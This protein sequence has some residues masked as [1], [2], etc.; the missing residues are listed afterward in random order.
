ML[1][2]LVF[3][4]FFGSVFKIICA[5]HIKFKNIN[6]NEGLQSSSVY[7]SIEDEMGFLWFLTEKGVSQYDGS[8][9][10]YFEED[11]LLVGRGFY[12]VKKDIK[13]N[14]W[15]IS[16]DFRLFKK[17]N[18]NIVQVKT[19]DLI[20]W[21]DFDTNG[22]GYLLSRKGDI[23]KLDSN[24]NAKRIFESDEKEIFFNLIAIGNEQ[25][26]VT[27]EYGVYQIDKKGEKRRL[28][29]PIAVK[30]KVVVPR[31]FKLNEN[32]ILVSTFSGIFEVDINVNN[33]PEK[34]EGFDGIEFFCLYKN[35]NDSDIWLGSSKGIYRF[36]KGIIKKENA[37]VYL[38]G[39]IVFDIKEHSDNLLWIC[40]A[41]NGV[42]YCYLN[43]LNIDQKD[44]LKKSAIKFVKTD[45]KYVYCIDMDGDISVLSDDNK[46][47]NLFADKDIRGVKKCFE[48]KHDGFFLLSSNG[49]YQIK[50]KKIREYKIKELKKEPLYPI[51][52]DGL[53]TIY[54]ISKLGLIAGV[55]NK[56]KIVLNAT[57]IWEHISKYNPRL[58]AEFLE[59]SNPKTVFY[60]S[61]NNGIMKV[62][63]INNKNT[64]EKISF[65]YKISNIVST[66]LNTLFIGTYNKG[67]C[68]YNTS[69]LKFY[70]IS[71]GL[72]SNLCNKV[73][74][75]KNAIW[76]CTNKGISR[77][78]LNNRDEVV[79][80]TNFTA[81]DVLV[82]NEVNDLTIL[83]G[84]VYAA[85]NLGVSVFSESIVMN[86]NNPHFF[87]DQVLINNKPVSINA[88]Y[89]LSYYENN[90]TIVYKAVSFR[91][92][93]NI[94]YKYLFINGKD[95]VYTFTK[96][97]RIQY[98]SL[99]PGNYSLYI[100]VRDIDGNWCLNPQNIYISIASP[101]WQTWWFYVIVSSLT[102]AIIFLIFYLKNISTRTKIELNDKINRAEITA[103]RLHIS[104]HFIF[105]ILNSLQYFILFN[106]NKEAIKYL[107]LF[108]SMI[109][110]IMKY[111]KLNEISMKSEIDLI[112]KYVALEQMRFKEQF[113]FN[114]TCDENLLVFKIPPLIIQPF[115]E[116]AIKYG[117][118]NKQGQG[119]ISLN[120]VEYKGFLKCTIIDNGIGRVEAEQ[121][122]KKNAIHFFHEST[123][124][125][126][127]NERLKRLSNY[128]LKQENVIVTDLYLDDKASGT[129]VEILI[130]VI[131]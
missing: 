73:F 38:N 107:S 122:K 10:N 102:T 37:T 9:F 49:L 64:Y 70:N 117:I 99:S 118:I 81:K 18:K 23:Y 58:P 108:S 12:L 40:T 83:D 39:N 96:A 42:Y 127:T 36:R 24:N 35:I 7:N 90:V 67:L 110:L 30:Q 60:I 123:G 1:K 5:Q 76:V 109:R 51:I 20:C 119:L 82:F 105:N 103:L 62:T 79:S 47:T 19:D 33:R 74:Y 43:A 32:K 66:R 121:L 68:V 55:P 25:F 17:N 53:N 29:I 80:V 21:I 26:I 86:K 92:A 69:G 101:F 45:G 131:N 8:T 28:N 129:K 22:Q 78:K 125:M 4:I 63:S 91:S 72:L 65:P 114:I 48:T 106:K 124:I 89:N 61:I 59:I 112:K 84:K 3:F 104:P 50:D 75:A 14:F 44:G 54:T 113:D 98:S 115:I 2:R 120:I 11:S 93:S 126:F 41:E 77:L 6:I 52:Q 128:K 94:Y 57:P 31:I 71:N 27:G 116:N 100:W 111:S 56:S 34:I 88:T 46:V 95:S 16:N 97:D 13:A 130:P 15:F 85:T 87:I